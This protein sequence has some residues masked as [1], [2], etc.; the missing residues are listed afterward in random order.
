MNL[1]SLGSINGNWIFIQCIGFIGVLLFVISY[2]IKANKG[3]FV[4]QM[5]GCLMFCIQF[6]L[7]GAYTGAISLIINIIRNILLIKSK[8]WKWAKSKIVLAIILIAFIVS[9]IVT[10]NGPIS[11]LPFASIAVTTLGYW[12]NNALKIRLSQMIGSPCYLVYDV[13][14]QSWGGVV[15][16]SIAI[17]S[18][19][20]SICRFGWKNLS[21]E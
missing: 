2:Q 1:E 17:I 8:D 4:C 5:L 13:L 18:I 7:M 3:L 12:T 6:F 19:I 10:W 14:V 20:V 15:S 16:E 9:T 21:N 11:L